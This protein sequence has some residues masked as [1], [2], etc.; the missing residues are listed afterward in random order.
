ME[1]SYFW[2]VTQ[3]GP[4]SEIP[5]LDNFIIHEDGQK[6][7]LQVYKQPSIVLRENEGK[8]SLSTGGARLHTS[9]SQKAANGQVKIYFEVGVDSVLTIFISHCY[10]VA[11]RTGSYLLLDEN[12][13][14]FTP[15]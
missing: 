12:N 1:H 10:V 13:I 9:S 8:I 5:I 15:G 14:I 11:M 2:Q 4:L 6:M 3:G 7:Q